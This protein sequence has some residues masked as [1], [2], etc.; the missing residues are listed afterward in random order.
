MSKHPFA[1]VL[2]ISDVQLK[3]AELEN[4]L[5][6]DV[7]RFE[8][9]RKGGGQYAQVNLGEA[10]DAV[11]PWASVREFLANSGSRFPELIQNGSLS[12]A[13]IDAA[14]RF[15]EEQ[16]MISR[17]IPADVAKLAGEAGIDIEVSVYKSF[18]E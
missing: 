15:R 6:C 2:R 4:T 3:R 1:V 7:E 18:D 9:Q 5:D 10:A 13:F 16:V 17:R 8:P 12:G 14:Y 11:D